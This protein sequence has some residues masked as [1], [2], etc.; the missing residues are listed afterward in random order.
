MIEFCFDEYYSICRVSSVNYLSPA[1]GRDSE[2]SIY[3]FAVVENMQHEPIT[4]ISALSKSQL[5]KN[6]VIA[7]RNNRRISKVKEE[8]R[9]KAHVQ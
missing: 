5:K 2:E 6:D 1:Y 4:N 7:T 3:F 8:E 9:K